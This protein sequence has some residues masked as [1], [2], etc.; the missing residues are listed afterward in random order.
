MKVKD[1]K[2]CLDCDEVY[3]AG[4]DVCPGCGSSSSVELRNWL[5]P[6]PTKEELD[7]EQRRLGLMRRADEL[8]LEA[9]TLITFD[10][11]PEPLGAC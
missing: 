8:L 10:G 3:S 11:D 9:R 7:R 2:I 5:P 6:L 1:T 4:L